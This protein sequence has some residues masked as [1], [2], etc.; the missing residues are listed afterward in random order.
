MSPSLRRAGASPGASIGTPSGTASGPAP[1]M[2]QMDNPGPGGN[3]SPGELGLTATKTVGDKSYCSFTPDGLTLFNSVVATQFSGVGPE[4]PLRPVDKHI[5]RYLVPVGE[6]PEFSIADYIIQ[7]QSKGNAIVV[8][9]NALLS[10][11]DL[12]FVSS[13]VGP[14]SKVQEGF[15]AVL[16]DPPGGWSTTHPMLYVGIGVGVVSLLGVLYYMR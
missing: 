1:M 9:E 13:L 10:T 4:V 14:C 7:E 15:T 16:L 6:S 3:S 8:V 11:K 2:Q 12:E 5:G